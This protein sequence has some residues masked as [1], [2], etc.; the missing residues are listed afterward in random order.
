MP[1]MPLCQRTP[2][3][4]LLRFL[5]AA[6]SFPRPGGLYN[7]ADDG[8]WTNLINIYHLMTGLYTTA[9]NCVDLYVGPQLVAA[10]GGAC[11][12]QVSE[13]RRVTVEYQRER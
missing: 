3:P 8:Q 10:R 7:C 11:E 13:S 5:A 6:V 12:S 1:A 4:W 2:P 9:C